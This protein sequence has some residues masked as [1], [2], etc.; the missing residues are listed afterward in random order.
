MMDFTDNTLGAAKKALTDVIGPAVDEN[1]ALA[2]EQLRLVIEYLDFVQRRTDDIYTHVRADLMHAIIVASKIQRE[3]GESNTVDTLASTIDA[4]KELLL[5]S[6]ARQDELKSMTLNLNEA[7]TNL[8]RGLADGD[9]IVRSSIQ[10]I[11]LAESSD[12]IEYER[13]WFLPFGFDP[14][15]A[16]AQSLGSLHEHLSNKYKAEIG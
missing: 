10:R 12:I 14:E 15:P 16:K 7:L 3:L 13:A 6:G 1:D 2:A 8:I 5:D 9:A 11:V 4:A